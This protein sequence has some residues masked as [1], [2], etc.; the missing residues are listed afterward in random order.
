VFLRRELPLVVKKMGK[1]SKSLVLNMDDSEVSDVSQPLRGG[2]H[3]CAVYDN[4]YFDSFGSP[5]P[6]ELSSYGIKKYNS[7]DYQS[8]D[9]VNCGNWCILFIKRMSTGSSFED[10]M[11]DFTNLDRSELMAVIQK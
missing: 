3:W 8:A 6:D 4:C 7:T 2:T 1:S 10:C 11:A 9:E 5:P